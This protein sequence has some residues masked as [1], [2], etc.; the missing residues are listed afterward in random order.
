M[1]FL[2]E[3]KTGCEATEKTYNISNAFGPGTANEHIVQLSFK[4]FC[5]EDQS[6][7]DEEHSDWPLEVDIKADPLTH[8]WNTKVAEELHIDHSMVIRHLKQIGKVK[9]SIS[10]CLMSWLK[11]K[12][13]VILKCCLLLLYVT[14]M[15]HFSIGLWHAMKSGFYMTT[16]N[17]ELSDW[18]EKL[19]NNSQSQTCTNKR[20]MVTISWSAA[21]LIHYN[22]LN[23]GETITSEKYAQQINEM[24]Q[25]LQHL[26]PALVNRKG[27]ILHNNAQLHVAQPTFEKL[28]E[29][30]YKVLPHPPYSPDLLPTD[31]YFF[32][33]HNFL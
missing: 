9:N 18:T 5:K 29:L 32:K 15:N 30:G 22:F 3:F 14:T 26:Q 21:G 8:K 6:L 31:Y 25:K 23:P 11:I 33:H 2:F 13:I 19:Q 28:S 7:E 20:V 27:P 4:K 16:G 10:G 1:I 24:H 17:D 12:T